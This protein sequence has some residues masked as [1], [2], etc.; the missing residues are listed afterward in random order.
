MK[1]API[2]SLLVVSLIVCP[3]L[4]IFVGPAL[5][6]AQ[7]STFKILGIIALCSALYCFIV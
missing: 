2:A 1:L 7:L 6:P 3:L 4:Y 5:D